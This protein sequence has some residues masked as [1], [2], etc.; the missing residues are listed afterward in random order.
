VKTIFL[1]FWILI[2]GWDTREK[3]KEFYRQDLLRNYPS[4][5]LV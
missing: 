4:S 1:Y 3:F 2:F 5:A